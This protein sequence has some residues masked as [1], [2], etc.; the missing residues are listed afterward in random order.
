MDEI[1]KAEEETRIYERILK[2]VR[3]HVK[4]PLGENKGLTKKEIY[5]SR[6]LYTRRCLLGKSS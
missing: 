3:Q 5:D 6:G 4:Q 2:Y 1:T